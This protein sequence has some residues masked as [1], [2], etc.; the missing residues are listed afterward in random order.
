M[1]VDK[2]ENADSYSDLGANFQKAF[3]YLKNSDLINLENGKYEIDGENIFVSI[4]DYN[5]KPESEGKFEAHKV[6]TDIQFIIK[7]EEKLGWADI[8]NCKA[9]T[10]YDDKNDI[11]FLDC[12]NGAGDF[13]HAKKNYFVIFTP[14]DAHMPCIAESEPSYVKKAV[15]KIKTA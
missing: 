15:V 8:K 3:E 2:I 1:I 5:T 4:Q 11:V 13:V 6:Y 9:T 7:G 12:Q 10:F 14:D